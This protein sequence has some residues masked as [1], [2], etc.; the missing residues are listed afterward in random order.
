[1]LLSV[2]GKKYL[3]VERCAPTVDRKFHA[4]EMCVP[5]VDKKIHAVERCAPTVDKKF[6][7][8]ERCAPAVDKK[9]HGVERRALVVDMKFH[10]VERRFCHHLKIPCQL[11]KVSISPSVIPQMAAYDSSILIVL[12]LFSAL[13]ILSCENL[14]MPVKKTKRK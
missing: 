11:S 13:K 1:M 7:A 14:V 12:I 9:F 2:V 4:V 6:H 8:V 5:T 3:V 10:G